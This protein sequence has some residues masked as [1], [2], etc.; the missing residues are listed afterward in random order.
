MGNEKD[1]TRD[2]ISLSGRDNGLTLYADANYTC[3]WSRYGAQTVGM[4]R[5][6]LSKDHR[7]SSL[8]NI[9]YSERPGVRNVMAHW[10][11]AVLRAIFRNGAT[12]MPVVYRIRR[13][14]RSPLFMTS[15]LGIGPPK[16]LSMVCFALHGRGGE[17]ISLHLGSSL[18]S[19]LREA[20][21]LPIQAV[22]R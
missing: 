20:G 1:C 12:R 10:C 2:S 17:Y 16:Q 14:S 7:Q 22:E 3:F 11:Q 4:N 19:G 21:T 15:P 6:S 8:R 13:S 9:N 18:P 5:S